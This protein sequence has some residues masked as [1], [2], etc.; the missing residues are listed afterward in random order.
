MKKI[1]LTTAAITTLMANTGA[2]FATAETFYLKA[3]VG[4]DK[5]LDIKTDIK[6][7]KEKSKNDFFV[8][9]GAGYYVMDDFRAEL[10]FDHYLKPEFKGS[11][12]TNPIIGQNR[13]VSA[14]AK[15]KADVLL[16]NGFVDVF[17]AKVAKIFVGA[18]VGVSMVSGKADVDDTN[19]VTGQKEA[20]SAKYEKKN[21]LAYAVHVGTSAQI[22]T[23]INAELTYSFRNLGELK[24][25]NGLN[26]TSVSGGNIRGHHVAAG[27][28][29]DI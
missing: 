4:G 5:F 16:L 13:Q 6:E 23:G 3:N 18:G 11:G 10:S 24:S 26:G 27:I 17:D 19:L 12:K 7:L 8:G 22:S 15:V 25:K 14:K 2:S 29:F 20:R 21:N 9:L 28:R 1:L